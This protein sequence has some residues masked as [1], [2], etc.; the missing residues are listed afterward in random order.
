[1]ITEYFYAETPD[2]ALK[3]AQEYKA[4]LDSMRQPSIAG[5]F[6]TNPTHNKPPFYAQVNYWGLD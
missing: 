4:G 1:M 3:M 2:A 6:Q 5:P